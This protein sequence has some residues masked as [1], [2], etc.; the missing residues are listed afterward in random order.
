MK[1]HD[2][3]KQSMAILNNAGIPTARLDCLVLLES[4]LGKDKSWLLAHPEFEINT[5]QIDKLNYNIAKRSKH[6]PLAYIRRKTEFYGREFYIDHRVLEPRPESETMI[7]LLKTIYSQNPYLSKNNPRAKKSLNLLSKLAIIDI[8][9]G[10][11][12]LAITAK[13]EI[14]TAAVIASDID[15]NCLKIASKNAKALAAEIQFYQGDL[16]EALPALLLATCYLL[17][18]NLPYVPEDFQ[19]NPAAMREPRQ[20]IFGGQDGLDLYRKLFGQIEKLNHLPQFILAEAMPPQHEKLAAIAQAAGYS[21]QKTD[22][23]ILVF[24]RANHRTN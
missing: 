3:L 24:V 8:G 9:T 19:I 20:A 2:W 15:G 1:I 23:F 6:E 7:D 10:S 22:D 16:L 13:L 17:V 12:A 21:L 11:G 14:P 5:K 4:E 18:C